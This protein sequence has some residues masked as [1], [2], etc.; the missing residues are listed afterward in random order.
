MYLHMHAQVQNWTFIDGNPLRLQTSL[1]IKW[2]NLFFGIHVA[3][4]SFYIPGRPIRRIFFASILGTTAAAICY[5]K[6]AVDITQTNYQRLKVFVNEQRSKY[7]QKQAEKAAKE[8]LKLRAE[9]TQPLEDQGIPKVEVTEEEVVESPTEVTSVQEKTTEPQMAAEMKP[10]SSFWSKIPFLDKLTGGN[11]TSSGD[12][13]PVQTS[14]DKVVTEVE[15]DKDQV[16]VQ[17]DSPGGDVKP[18]GDIG[19]SNPEDKDMYSTRS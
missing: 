7:N 6:Q 15:S 9:E 13:S 16:I 19:Q 18:E 11:T 3:D 8:E 2:L 10:Q 5:P 17:E 12:L 4:N 14:D 1:F